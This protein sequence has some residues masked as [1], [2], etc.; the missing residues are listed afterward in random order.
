MNDGPL[1]TDFVDDI[2]FSAQ[3][4][5]V[6]AYVVRPMGADPDHQYVWT[7]EVNGHQ[8]KGPVY[9]Y[10]RKSERAQMEQELRDWLPQHPEVKAPPL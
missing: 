4:Q 1:H 5:K 7:I 10:P 3:G 8:A 2:R 6:H 9:R